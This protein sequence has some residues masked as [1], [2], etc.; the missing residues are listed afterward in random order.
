MFSDIT[1]TSGEK[2]R[3]RPAAWDVV[4]GIVELFALSTDLLTG[5]IM[6]DSREDAK[7]QSLYTSPVATMSRGLHSLF[8]G[9]SRA[10][11]QL[12]DKFC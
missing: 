2:E 10:P 8:F 9:D 11:R 7:D 3:S 12:T 4:A 6:L 1:C 5:N